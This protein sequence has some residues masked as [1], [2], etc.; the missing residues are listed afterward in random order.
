MKKLKDVIKLINY[1]L[2]ALIGFETIYKILSL[3][4]FT[5]LFLNIFNL[6]TKITGYKY[7]TFENFFSFLLNPLTI[8]LLIV[9]FLFMMIFTLYDIA[10]IIVI[11]DASFQKKKISITEASSIALKKCQGVFKIKNILVVFLVLFLIPF[12]NIG[13]SSSLITT[14]KIPEFILEYII[15]NK[16]LLS[17]VFLLYLFLL[18]LLLRWLYIFHY[19]VIEDKNFKEARKD[20]VLLSKKCHFKDLI[21]LIVIQMLIFVMYL[22]FLILGI[23][24]IVL[25][26]KVFNKILIIKSLTT[27]IIWL[28]I[29]LSFICFVILTTPVGYAVISILYYLHKEEKKEK[30]SHINIKNKELTKTNKWLKRITLV[31][32]GCAFIVSFFFTYGLYKGKYNFNIEMTRTLEVT[33]H[34]GASVFYPENTMSAFRGAKKLGADWIELDV[35]ETKDGK[36]IVIH[37]TNFKRTANLNKN[38]WE[39]TYDEVEK[40]DAGSFFSKKYKNEKIP[41][42]E[43]VVEFAKENNIKLNIE[44]KPTG[45]ERALEK[46]VVDII[47]DKKFVDDCV[48]TSQVYDVLKKVKK[49]NKN[50]STVYVM[51]LAY[52]DITSLKYADNFSIEAMSVNKKLVRKVHNEGKKLYAWTVNTKESINEMINAKVDNI[53]TDDITLAKEVIY[54]SKTSN[55]VNE[56]IKLVRSIF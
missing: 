23:M 49:Y 19:Y 42:L 34:R 45:H 10:T 25:V 40:L 52:G 17:L 48:I 35:Q 2:K 15:K 44:I 46:S 38:T 36:V 41:L 18:S 13:V 8:I 4:I 55:I 22:V 29:A 9:L 7:L 11:L 16:I 50:I 31:A 6:I 28:F 51:S 26:S 21:T 32:S 24:L 30:I 43:K 12:L 3:L 14:I 39:L 54:S 27:T 56:Y 20:S 53:I 37:D 5:P 33:A 47:N 1:N